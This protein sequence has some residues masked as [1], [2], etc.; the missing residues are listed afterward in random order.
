MGISFLKKILLILIIP[1]FSYC[2]SSNENINLLALRKS[3]NG[4]A[5]KTRTLKT[6]LKDNSFFQEKY[7]DTNINLEYVLRYHFYTGIEFGA[8]KNQLISMD[9]TV[10]NIK[11]KTPSKITDEIIDLI[12]GMFYGQ[13]EYKKF[14][15]LNLEKK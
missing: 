14:E 13:R 1:V 3:E 5:K 2:Q 7:R 9:G 15:R 6:T 4:F 11:S 12:G 8:K 10:F